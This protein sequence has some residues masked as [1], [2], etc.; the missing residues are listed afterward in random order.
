MVNLPLNHPGQFDT[1]P[2]LAGEL[3]ILRPLVPSDFDAL[4]SVASDPYIWEQHPVPDRHEVTR[5]QE[6]FQNALASGGTLIAIDRSDQQVI[7]TSRYHGYNP[8]QREIEIGWT[9]LARS[10]WGGRY[11][12]EIK[13]LMLD[14]AFRFID[15]VV[16]LVGPQNVRSQRAVKRI[17]GRRAGTRPD[18]AGRENFV[19]EIT[20][21]SYRQ[22]PVQVYFAR[23][24]G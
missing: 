17:G 13:R 3:V 18:G 15:R 5:F 9:F 1:Q 12:G 24:S 19:Y 22:H 8:V 4:Y 2:V 21:H 20:A 16:F 14:H 23:R 7:G 6:F 10:H 11:N